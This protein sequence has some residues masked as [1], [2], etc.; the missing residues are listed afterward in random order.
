MIVGVKELAQRYEV[1]RRTVTNWVNS[2]PACPSWKDGNDR[3]FDTL[4][5]D[6]WKTARAVAE[7]VANI[8]REPPTDIADAER[9]KAIADAM[10]AEIRVAKE[11]GSV[12]PIETHEHVVG[13]L[14]DRAMAVV[15]NIPDTYSL[16]LERLGIPPREARVV[17]EKLQDALVLALRGVVD[18]A[19][20]DAVT[21]ED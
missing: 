18:D 15:Q 21:A 13:E 10:L 9:R 3:K 19:D 6:E 4:K 2:T 12:I 1:D 11:E 14:G 7:A 17:L 8:S 16:D 5:V 20:D